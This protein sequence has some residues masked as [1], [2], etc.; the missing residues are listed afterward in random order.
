MGQWF[1]K[2]VVDDLV[3]FQGCP[4]PV[5]I[6]AVEGAKGL[7]VELFRDFASP[8]EKKEFGV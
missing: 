4:L 1:D 6:R 3:A 2:P 7:L 8:E 5:A